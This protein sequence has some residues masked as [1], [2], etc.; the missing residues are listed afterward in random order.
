MKIFTFFPS[1][2]CPFLFFFF[3]DI[4]SLGYSFES[5][6]DAWPSM[7][8]RTPTR[9]IRTIKNDSR[10]SAPKTQKICVEEVVVSAENPGTPLYPYSSST[11]LSNDVSSSLYQPQEFLRPP[12]ST[13]HRFHGEVCDISLNRIAI[14]V[15]RL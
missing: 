7:Q 11:E 6:G 3:F 4:C 2:F 15:H 5:F 13:V 10:V 8:G 1:L 14:A 12:N 9:F